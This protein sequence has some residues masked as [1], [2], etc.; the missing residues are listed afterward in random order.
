MF[1]SS[2]SDLNSA[3]ESCSDNLLKTTLD[4][5]SNN[6]LPPP[7]KDLL[8]PLNNNLDYFHP[9]FSSCSSGVQSRIADCH[10]PPSSLPPPGHCDD[11][12]P[13]TSFNPPDYNDHPKLPPISSVALQGSSPSK[14]DPI[15]LVSFDH[16]DS[17]PFHPDVGLP[18]FDNPKPISTLQPQYISL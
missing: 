14:N 18:S 16:S 3:L 6:L 2:S 7:K 17:K 13:K 5:F 1:S 4:D 8:A 9:N 10:T 11:S 12:S 15:S